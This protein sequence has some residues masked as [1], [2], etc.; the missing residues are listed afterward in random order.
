MRLFDGLTETGWAFDV[1]ILYRAQLAGFAITEI[2]VNWSEVDGSKLNPV[3]DA[4]RMGIAIFSIRRRNA[5]FLGET[6]RR[7]TPPDTRMNDG[8]ERGYTA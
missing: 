6:A 4:F 7:C 3:R 5:G 2:P 1:E 8:A